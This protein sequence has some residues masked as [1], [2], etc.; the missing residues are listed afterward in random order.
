MTLKQFL[1]EPGKV[2]ITDRV[3]NINKVIKRWNIYERM[4]MVDCHVMSLPQIAKELVMAYVAVYEPTMRYSIISPAMST[5]IM[6]IIVKKHDLISVPNESKCIGT[7]EEILRSLNRIRLNNPTD[8]FNNGTD[9]KLKEMRTLLKFY[10]DQLSRMNE[11]DYPMLIQKAIEYLD[12]ITDKESH[13]KILL[14]FL[15][16]LKNDTCIVKGMDLTSSEKAFLDKLEKVSG[17]KFSKDIDITNEN[18]KK[19]DLN[20]TGHKYHFFESY[21]IDGEVRYVTEKI[22]EKK[23]SYGDVLVIYSSDA[24]ENILRGEFENEGIAYTFAKGYHASSED[25]ISFMLDLISFVDEDY[26]YAELEKVISNPIMT[27]EGVK[28]SYRKILDEGIGW[29]RKRYI[30]FINDYHKRNDETVSDDAEQWKKDEAEN[31]TQFVGFLEAV[32]SV[33]DESNTCEQLFSRLMDLTNKYT[34]NADK[35]R[36]RISEQLKTQARAFSVIGGDESFDNKLTYITEY[37]SELRLSES[38]DAQ[39]VAIYPYGTQI[40]T[41]RSYIFVL[42]LSN[43]NISKT[44]AES[45]VFSDDE[46]RRYAV[47]SLDLASDKNVRHRKNFEYT[48][49]AFSGEDIYIGYSDYDTVNLLDNSRSL[50]YSDLM[51]YSGC[52]PEDINRTGYRLIEGNVKISK[53]DFYKAYVKDFEDD[54]TENE[55]G[56]SFD[57]MYFS[58]SSLQTLLYCPLQFYYKKI[59]RIPDIQ[60]SERVPDRWLLPNQKGNLFHRTLEDYVNDALVRGSEK[61]LDQNLLKKIF[62]EKVAIAL[63]EQPCPS[64]HIFEDEKEECFEAI[65]RYAKDLHNEIN[66]SVNGKKVI[67]CEVRFENYKYEDL[68]GTLNENYVPEYNICFTGS[69]DRVDGFVKDGVLNLEIIDYKTGSPDKKIE[70]IQAG[71]QIQHYIYALC[72]RKWAKDHLNDLVIRFGSKITAIKIASMNYIFPFEEEESKIVDATA[73]VNNDDLILPEYITEV[74]INTV[75]NIQHGRMDEFNEFMDDYVSDR[76][77]TLADKEADFCRYCNYT[78]VCRRKL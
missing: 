59:E 49:K 46:L 26:S 16:W 71:M 77:Q 7:S 20:T 5:M 3:S 70:E 27:L 12:K 28:R 61:T 51:R 69:A 6:H 1:S 58:A 35:C 11:L 8:E 62:N 18:D 21:G 4:D 9:I 48:L 14:S 33:F 50:L 30:D 22:H 56:I 44:R 65:C 15:P 43:E 57:P 41:D 23:M 67:G 17:K 34:S 54:S 2:I 72:I 73:L 19:V 78:H 32:L 13:D 29:G 25:Y 63:K 66:E 68:I 39:A 53:D 42:G 37:L 47:G 64:Q 76:M 38:D 75:G 24:Y 10:T 60:Y 74:M 45:P 55:N 52:S 31:K 40:V 36:I